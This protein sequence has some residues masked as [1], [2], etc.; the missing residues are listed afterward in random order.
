MAGV[1]IVKYT[2]PLHKAI[3]AYPQNG[4]AP[5]KH[6][7]KLSGFD[8]RNQFIILDNCFNN[9]IR[10]VNERVYYVKDVRTGRIRSPVTPQS[11]HHI[12]KTLKPFTNKL[13]S[14]I[15]PHTPY[16]ITTIPSLYVGRKRTIYQN[17]VDSLTITPWNESDSKIKAF[18]KAEPY[19]IKKKTPEQVV[20]RIISPASPRHNANMARYTKKIEHDL[21]HAID[22]TVDELSHTNTKIKTIMKG[23]NSLQMA[24][25]IAAAWSCFD[26]P[27]A[28]GFDATRF[29]QHVSYEMLQ[30]E[31]SVYLK[32]YTGDDKRE[33][34]RMLDQQ[35]KVKATMFLKDGKIKY[36]KLG[37]RCSGHMN[38]GLGNCL[39]MVAMTT[40]FVASLGIK[41]YRVI[42]NGDDCVLIV[43]RKNQHKLTQDAFD[44][45]FNALGFDIVMEPHVTVL[46]EIEFCQMHPVQ[47]DGTWLMVRNIIPSLTKDA[48]SI[49]PLRNNKEISSWMFG[50]GEGGLSLTG[51]VPI[52]QEY[53]S[54]FTKQATVLNKHVRLPKHN[55][56]NENGLY[57]LTRGMTQKYTKISDSSRISFYRAFNILPHEQ[58][59]VER[60]YINIKYN[61]NV[62]WCKN[63]IILQH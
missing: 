61:P 22:R 47:V 39:I 34:R 21:Y 44:L 4:T 17:A 40:A 8:S 36:T 14:R 54:A 30:W 62:K 16:D 24:R 45:F 10:S 43:E 42:N 27:V 32:Y 25:E 56:M 29:D 9:A 19:S 49:R 20:N 51:G 52:C 12:E 37:S 35:L 15:R 63:K 7:S 59:Y 3:K 46:E 18:L 23:M 33:F 48:I 5:P 1:R 2:V 50:V 38:T 41:K 60:E 58:E 26:N 57:F 31:H 53:Y 13:S 11:K 6:C 55:Q 28:I